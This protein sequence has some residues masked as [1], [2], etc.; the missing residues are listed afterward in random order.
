MPLGF[1]NPSG[2]SAAPALLFGAFFLGPSVGGGIKVEGGLAS[3][4]TGVLAFESDLL[5]PFELAATGI[6]VEFEEDGDSFNGDSS[7][8]TGAGGSNCCKSLG[9]SLRVMIWLCL[10]D[11]L[12]GP[13]GVV[14]LFDEAIVVRLLGK[15]GARSYGRRDGAGK[16][17]SK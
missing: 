4:G 9:D 1:G 7:L 5:S 2:P 6:V 12:R 17:R 3:L 16:G 15:C 14:V 8:T 11:F 13:V 10:V